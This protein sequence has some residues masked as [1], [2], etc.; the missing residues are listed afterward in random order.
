MPSDAGGDDLAHSGWPVCRLAASCT[1]VLEA[2]RSPT[3]ALS[4]GERAGV[5]SG[6]AVRGY[7]L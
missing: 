6:A 1:G 7:R 5:F 3:A 4:T 2:A